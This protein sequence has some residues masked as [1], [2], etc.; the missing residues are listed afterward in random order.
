M[1]L[2]E[3][4]L[5]RLRDRL[6]SQLLVNEAAKKRLF[7]WLDEHLDSLGINAELDQLACYYKHRNDDQRNRRLTVLSTF[8]WNGVR[9]V[10]DLGT[11]ETSKIRYCVQLLVGDLGRAETPP[12]DDA[13]P[14]LFEAIHAIVRAIYPVMLGTPD[15]PSDIPM[16]V[17]GN[18]PRELVSELV[19]RMNRC[20]DGYF[21]NSDCLLQFS[22]LVE[23]YGRRCRVCEKAGV[24]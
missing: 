3:A 5:A 13:W 9:I 12:E 19:H 22:D 2:D 1:P 18:V 6:R 16:P 24:I 7:A 14:S 23:A 17:A 8:G 4:E 11:S 21:C 15:V 10:E 20:G